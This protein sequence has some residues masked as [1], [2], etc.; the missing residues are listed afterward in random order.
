[1]KAVFVFA[2]ILA[3]VSA[4]GYLSAGRITTALSSE[5]GGAILNNPNNIFAVVMA[6]PF[7]MWACTW[8]AI[9]GGSYKNCIYTHMYYSLGN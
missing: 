3:L 7:A 2:L 8:S 9:F 4:G 6:M 1:M 5:Y